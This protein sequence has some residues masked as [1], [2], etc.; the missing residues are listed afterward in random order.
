MSH[1]MTLYLGGNLLG[2]AGVIALAEAIR[3]GGLP[4][5]KVLTLQNN[6]NIGNEGAKRL[7]MAV[8]IRQAG[9]AAA[10]PKPWLN[11]SGNMVS[12]ALLRAQ[13]A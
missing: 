11:L 3:N 13:L 6:L 1:L 5:L 12:D 4:S 8:K 10:P 9:Q 7:W 2:D